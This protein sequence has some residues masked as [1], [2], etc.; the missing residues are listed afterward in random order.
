[1]SNEASA[2]NIYFED[3][4]I[5]MIWDIGEAVYELDEMIDF[6]RRYDP[7]PFHIDE[8]WSRTGPFGEIIASGLLTLAKC[9]YLDQ[10]ASAKFGLRNG[11]AAEL[12]S[13][14]FPNP[15]RAGDIISFHKECTDKRES[16]SKRDRGIVT[17]KTTGHNQDRLL[18]LE[19]TALL[20]YERRPKT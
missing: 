15:A 1:M 10:L 20:V 2:K 5:G 13:I 3:L 6:A 17:F 14:K 7:E 12:K 19:T 9:R 18:M 16:R 4:R 11:V 8:Q